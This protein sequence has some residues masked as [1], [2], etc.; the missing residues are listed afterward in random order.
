V[1]VAVE[2]NEST[3]RFV[4]CSCHTPEHL[5][6][7]MWFKGEEELYV[8]YSLS[9][10]PFFQRVWLAIKYIFGHQSKFGMFGEL[11]LD[12]GDKNNLIYILKEHEDCTRK[13]TNCP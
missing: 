7:I 10:L 12:R 11:V 9:P 4:S 13:S 3:E 6:K 5:I 8:C 1:D 2:N